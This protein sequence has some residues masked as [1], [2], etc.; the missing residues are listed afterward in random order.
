MRTSFDIP[1]PLLRRARKLARDRGVT[2][3]QV[4]L[5]GL[6]S[7]VE[8]AAAPHAYRMKDFSFGKEGLVHGLCWGDERLDEIAYGDR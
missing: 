1:E 3:R 8:R 5:D 4:L 7:A 2:L 6:Q